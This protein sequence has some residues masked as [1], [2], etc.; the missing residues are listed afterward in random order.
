MNL[1]FIIPNSIRDQQESAFN[2]KTIPVYDW[3]IGL[4]AY[5]TD[6]DLAKAYDR[7]GGGMDS[8]ESGTRQFSRSAEDLKH[9]NRYG[10]FL[11]PVYWN[12]AGIIK[13]SASAVWEFGTSPFTLIGKL[14]EA[15][16]MASRLGTFNRAQVGLPDWLQW[17]GKGKHNSDEAMH[18]ARQ[19]TLDFQRF[20]SY[21]RTANEMIPFINA[22]IQ[23]IDK[24]ARVVKEDPARA[25]LAAFLYVYAPMMAFWLWDKDKEGYK[26]IPLQEKLNNFIIMNP[27]GITYIKIPKGHIAK[28][29]GNPVQVAIEKMNGTI[30]KDDLPAAMQIMKDLSPI[31]IS[32]IPV[33]L[34]LIVEPIAN[35]DLY[36]N[37]AIEKPY[38]KAI[39][40]AGLRY[41]NKTSE[42][43]KVVGKALNISPVMMQ[44]E[45]EIVGAG[46]AKNI[47]WLADIAMGKVDAEK[48][49]LERVPI[50]KRFYGK[51]NDWG[52]DID[53]AIRKINEKLSKS[54]SFSVRSMQQYAKY[55][56]K[57][58]GLALKSNQEKINLLNSKRSELMQAKEAIRKLTATSE[59]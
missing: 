52:S 28:F 18:I 21:G 26:A 7:A 4:K 44:H 19:A 58:I 17:Y 41:E 48:F 59:K 50:S 46:T 25:A 35:Y 27:D 34:R 5:L 45:I 12:E 23:G 30:L 38:H 24:M 6:S 11:D 40:T 15:S 3:F 1:D 2:A 37:R 47:L 13:G 31:D 10:K 51:V 53:E 20:G 42:L 36:W 55:S 54:R 43:I 57:D 16:E 33:S 22:A 39:L 29:M 9:G 49:N 32:S 14:A 56:N 8:V